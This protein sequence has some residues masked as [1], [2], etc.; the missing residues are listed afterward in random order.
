[1]TF[2]RRGGGVFSRQ[3]WR[4]GG[5]REPRGGG[6]GVGCSWAQGRGLEQRAAPMTASSTQPRP[7]PSSGRGGYFGGISRSVDFLGD[8]PARRAPRLS[9]S[10]SNHEVSP[11]RLLS[12]ERVST[13]ASS[14]VGFFWG[15]EGIICR[16]ERLIWRSTPPRLKATPGVKEMVVRFKSD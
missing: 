1:M 5:E 6:G 7:P 15:G 8:L 10:S 11:T 16:N 12:D 9:A 4:L 2:G 13:P 3:R 14:S